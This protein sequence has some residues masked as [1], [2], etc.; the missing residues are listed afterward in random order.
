MSHRV[1][2]VDSKVSSKNTAADLQQRIKKKLD[3]ESF[4]LNNREVNDGFVRGTATL[5]VK[6]DHNNSTE[7]NRFYDWVWMF[8]QDNQAS[9]NTDG[10]VSSEG[11]T[12]FRVQVHDC[13]HLEGLSEPCEIGNA[14]SF[15]LR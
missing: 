2:Q 5:S 15:D 11:F 14:D 8:A 3:S 10:S 13:K 12:R 1:I 9:F 7:A 6:T 4:D